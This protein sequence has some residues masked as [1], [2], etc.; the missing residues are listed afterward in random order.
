M[1][2]PSNRRRLSLLGLAW[3]SLA[4]IHV[5]MQVLVPRGIVADPLLPIWARASLLATELASLALFLLLVGFPFF[6]IGPRL[7]TAS[8]FGLRS[9]AGALVLAG[10]ASSWTSFWLSGQFLDRQGLRFAAANFSSVFGYAV[11]VHPL[12][13]Y[14]L[15]LLLLGLSAAVCGGTSR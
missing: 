15:P 2:E 9:S 8:L 1:I 7:S 11:R 4:T 13:V 10:L 3:L 14:G 6:I 12:L 5:A